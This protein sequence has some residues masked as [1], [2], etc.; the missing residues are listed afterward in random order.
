[1]VLGKNKA[2]TLYRIFY[3]FKK[4]VMIDQSTGLGG[5]GRRPA[6]AARR[7]RA[8]A[9]ASQEL[10]DGGRQRYAGQEQGPGW[11]GARL[12]SSM[13]ELELDIDK[14]Q[15]A[16]LG[17]RNDCLGEHGGGEEQGAC[18]WQ[19]RA[20]L[21]LMPFVARNLK[22]GA[23]GVMQANSKGQA[24]QEQEQNMSKL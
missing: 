20:E 13:L 21:W 15:E 12:G 1:M 5:A 18:R 17:E 16:G 24:G 9:V 23:D 10:S 6:A 22:P 14:L 8:A 2:Q 19:K 11:A 4:K 3:L 7:W